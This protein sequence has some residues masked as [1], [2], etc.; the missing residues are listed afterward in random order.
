M[1]SMMPVKVAGFE[2]GVRPMGSW[3]TA[4][5]AVICSSPSSP[6]W[7]PG[8][9]L[10]PLILRA[11]AAD[12]MSIASVLLPEPETPQT[13]VSAPI[14]N[15]AV[16]SLRLFSVAPLTVIAA[17]PMGLRFT[18]PSNVARPER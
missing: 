11:A 14:G 16:T 7:R 3:S 13:T 6:A 10:A 17:L 18:M 12:R 5:N 1:R 15:E 9:T 8:T 4:V 2:R